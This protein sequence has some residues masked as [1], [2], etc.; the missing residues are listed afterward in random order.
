[1]PN[2]VSVAQW[3]PSSLRSRNQ[4]SWKLFSD[5]DLAEC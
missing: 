5:A 2:L 1:M 4:L 3:K